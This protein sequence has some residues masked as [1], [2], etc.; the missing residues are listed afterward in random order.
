[1]DPDPNPLVTGTNPRIR[2]VSRIP[3]SVVA[4]LFVYGRSVVRLKKFCYSDVC[5]G[6]FQTFLSFSDI[7]DRHGMKK[8]GLSGK[9]SGPSNLAPQSLLVYEFHPVNSLL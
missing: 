3:N 2:I 5:S 4:V 6:S 8:H 1:L 7:T 9:S